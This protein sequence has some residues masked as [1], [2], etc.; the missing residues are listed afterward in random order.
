[1]PIFNRSQSLL[2][3]AMLLLLLAVLNVLFS[4]W[5]TRLRQTE[6]RTRIEW[7]HTFIKEWK[8]K[9]EWKAE[10]YPHIHSPQSPSITLQ[11]TFRD[12][13]IVNLP[14]ALLV[15]GD[16]IALR[17]GQ[18]SPGRCRNLKVKHVWTPV[19]FTDFQRYQNNRSRVRTNQTLFWKWM[20]SMRHWQS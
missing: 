9:C 5:D 20:K 8:E 16:V 19:T 17:P 18:P 7:I 6:M 14:W 3:Q 1:M 12:G 13:S 15:K 10:I 11:P 2:W 4:C